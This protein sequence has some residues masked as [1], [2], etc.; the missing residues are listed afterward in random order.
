MKYFLAY[1]QP[2]LVFVLAL[3]VVCVVSNL[4]QT[5]LSLENFVIAELTITELS[6]KFAMNMVRSR[7]G[8]QVL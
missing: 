1:S 5:L 8:H 7:E 6:V 4:V 2:A 3:H